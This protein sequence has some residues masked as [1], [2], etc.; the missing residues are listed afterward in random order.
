MPHMPEGWLNMAMSR[1][2]NWVEGAIS[3]VWND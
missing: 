2:G 3:G 1:I